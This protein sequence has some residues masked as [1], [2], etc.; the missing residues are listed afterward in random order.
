MHMPETRKN[1]SRPIVGVGAVVFKGEKILLIKRGKEPKKNQW[2]LPGGAQNLGET[3]AE[4]VVREVIEE[5]GLTVK[6][7]SFIDVIDYIEWGD[8]KG[9]PLFQYTLLDYSAD[10]VEGTLRAS[11]DAIDAQFFT[12]SDILALPLWS[13]TKR[14]I[15]QAASERGLC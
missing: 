11:S 7:A 4:A 12:L 13:E 10:Y 2:S 9:A 5:T 3:V 6:I 14:V 1:P 8:R 15:K